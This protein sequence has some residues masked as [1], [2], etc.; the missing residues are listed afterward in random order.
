VPARSQQDSFDQLIGI[1][2][3]IGT[4]RHKSVGGA[5]LA[6]GNLGDVVG[7]HIEP[8]DLDWPLKLPEAPCQQLLDFVAGLARAVDQFLRGVP[9]NR[10]GQRQGI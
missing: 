9:F 1:H 5:R 3:T 10:T 7:Q 8:P 2:R 6:G 4:Q